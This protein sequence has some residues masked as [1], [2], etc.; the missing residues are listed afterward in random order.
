MNTSME[1]KALVA[2]IVAVVL[3]IAGFFYWKNY[4]KPPPKEQGETTEAS[5]GGEI[6]TKATNPVAGELP[7]TTAPAPNPLQNIYKNPFE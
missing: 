3:A 6:Y 5:L 2:V 4:Y 1:K 7:E